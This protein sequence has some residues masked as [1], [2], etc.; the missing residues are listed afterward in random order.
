[1][2]RRRKC[3]RANTQMALPSPRLDSTG[4]NESTSASY[5]VQLIADTLDMSG[6]D[7]NWGR[8][9]HALS[10]ARCA[11]PEELTVTVRLTGDG[12]LN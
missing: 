2:G 11:D 6:F 4:V 1:M 12:S 5:G 7:R 10:I 8:E 9:G 3:M